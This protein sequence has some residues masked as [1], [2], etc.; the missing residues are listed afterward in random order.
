MKIID[1]VIIFLSLIFLILS[2]LK[3]FLVFDYK[4]NYIYLDEVQTQ[5]NLL[6]SQ[7]TKLKVEISLIKSSPYIYEKALEIG[8]IE[9]EINN[10]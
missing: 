5:I 7:N 9:P 6:S 1:A 3:V 2:F 8:M 10:D 4:R